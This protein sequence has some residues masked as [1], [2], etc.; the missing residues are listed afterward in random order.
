MRKIVTKENILVL[1]TLLSLFLG[2]SLVF[3]FDI[4]ALFFWLRFQ[5]SGYISGMLDH[6]WTVNSDEKN[7]LKFTTAKL[8]QW[9]EEFESSKPFVLA[10]INKDLGKFSVHIES[11]NVTKGYSNFANWQLEND[12]KT[13]E[14][15]R[16]TYLVLKNIEFK[17]V[18]IDDEYRN[19][20]LIVDKADMVPLK[21]DVKVTW[22]RNTMPELNVLTDYELFKKGLSLSI[23]IVFTILSFI[24]FGIS[25]MRDR[26]VEYL[27]KLKWV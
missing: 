13:L 9:G 15:L 2:L 21:S 11:T 24:F 4:K 27:V 17:R 19:V 22:R 8:P 23:L 12:G 20:F 16:H 10:K 7:R 6:E 26:M 25:S 3:E 18:Y 1:A 14:L 5:D